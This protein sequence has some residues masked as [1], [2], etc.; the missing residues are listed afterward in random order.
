MILVLLA[1]Q[2]TGNSCR[3]PRRVESERKCRGDATHAIAKR[4]DWRIIQ[5]VVRHLCDLEGRNKNRAVVG[6]K[7]ISRDQDEDQGDRE[8]FHAAIT[9]VQSICTATLRRSSSTD[10]RRIPFSDLFSTRIPST[11]LSGPAVTRTR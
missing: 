5:V 3:P 6:T 2:S 7:L 10:S 4:L 1:I 8:A 9:H 11:P